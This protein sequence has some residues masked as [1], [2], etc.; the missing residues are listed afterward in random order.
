MSEAVER[1]PLTAALTLA[2]FGIE[3]SGEQFAKVMNAEH[4]GLT[5]AEAFSKFTVALD[6]L[7]KRA[8]SG[9]LILRGRFACNIDASGTEEIAQLPA[10]SVLSYAA[11][12][13]R[14]DGLR[15]G[16][17]ALLWFSP[18]EAP[19]RQPSFTRADHYF[20]ITVVRGQVR[21]FL[22]KGSSPYQQVRKPPPLPDADLQE[23][24][25]ALPEEDKSKSQVSLWKMAQ[26]DHPN[27]QL[28]RQRM[29][30]FVPK[31]PPGRPKS[32]K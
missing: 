14:I 32:A 21:K 17:P 25:D 8:A 28:T 13:C 10:E 29:R 24:W 19:Y 22:G 1:I 26:K 5:R 3:K 7:L 4:F 31:R 18:A 30:G 15:F 9:D 12:D 16:D 6:E 27:H 23:W 20:D 2:A 11:F